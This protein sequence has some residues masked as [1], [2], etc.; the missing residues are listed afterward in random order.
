M[1]AKNHYRL[2]LKRLGRPVRSA[3]GRFGWELSRAS[4]PRVRFENFANLCHAYEQHLAESGEHI[5][6]SDSRIKLVARL[7]GTSPGEAYAIVRALAETASLPGDVCEF[8]VAQGETSALIASEILSS[9]RTL[10]LFDSF[11]GLP[12]PTAQDELKDD[13]FALGSMSAYAGMMSCPEDLVRARLAAIGF[14]ARRYT[15][16]Q[17]F[18]ESVLQTDLDLPGSVSFA[19]LDFDLYEPTKVTLEFLTEVT[20]PGAVILVDDYDFFSTGVKTA[21][22]EFVTVQ[23][24]TGVQFTCSVPDTRYGHFAILRRSRD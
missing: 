22:D 14:P 23:C 16:H 11:K 2:R 20:C 5:S 21:V 10:H 13:I 8:G 17:G 7:F 24:S 18:V 19:Y 1:S 4:D 9:D 3:L 12:E 15:I 6:P